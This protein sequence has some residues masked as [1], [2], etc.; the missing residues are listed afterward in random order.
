MSLRLCLCPCPLRCRA[1]AGRGWGGG[2]PEQSEPQTPQQGA[3][4]CG[5]DEGELQAPAR[6]W[7]VPRMLSLRSRYRMT[8]LAQRSLKKHTQQWFL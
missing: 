8:P 4:R 3:T 2:V 7:A 6:L 1:R 5:G